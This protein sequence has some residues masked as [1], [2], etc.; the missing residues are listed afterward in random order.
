MENT[1]GRSVRKKVIVVLGGLSLLWV[2]GCAVMYYEMCKPP[3]EFGRFMTRVPAPMAFL[4]FPF[5]KLWTI[6]RAGSISPGDAA[7]DFDLLALDKSQSIRFSELNR[8]QPVV[9]IF[10]SYT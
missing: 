8:K 5:E 10:G 9:L 1:R 6:A 4:V 7:P 3:E 2:I